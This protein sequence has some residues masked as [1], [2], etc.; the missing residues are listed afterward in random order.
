MIVS[1]SYRSDIPAFYARWAEIRLR[2]AAK[3]GG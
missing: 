3:A 1:A 2:M